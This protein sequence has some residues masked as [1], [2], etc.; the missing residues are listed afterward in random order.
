MVI[1]KNF[2]VSTI[3]I[4]ISYIILVTYLRNFLLING[5]LL[6]FDLFSKIKLYSTLLVGMGTSM[7]PLAVMLM[8][9]TSV[10]TGLNITVILKR[11]VDLKKIGKLHVAV[12]GSSLL[13]IIGGGCA[14][15]GLPII[16]L[17]GLTGSLAFLPFKG[18]E[19]PYISVFLLLLS[20]TFLIKTNNDPRYCKIK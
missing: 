16:S 4:A 12:G 9:L 19:L 6:S 20:L 8:V 11:F 18:A 14:A 10:L 1:S 2:I 7:T 17:L 3:L 13:G 15:C 5:T